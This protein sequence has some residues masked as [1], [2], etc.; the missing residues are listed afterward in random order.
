MLVCILILLHGFEQAVFQEAASVLCFLIIIISGRNADKCKQSLFKVF[1]YFFHSWK[2]SFPTLSLVFRMHM[3]SGLLNGVLII[4]WLSMS[5]FS[6]RSMLAVGEGRHV[7]LRAHH[8]Q[9]PLSR[10]AGALKY[11]T[12]SREPAGGRMWTVSLQWIQRQQGSTLSPRAV[13]WEPVGEP[14]SCGL[15]VT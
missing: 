8:G 7:L 15:L 11:S 5:S 10:Q 12:H 13:T 9:K 3:L 6:Y 4:N 1:I 14:S 2:W